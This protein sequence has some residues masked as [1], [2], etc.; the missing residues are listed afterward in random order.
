MRCD[1]NAMKMTPNPSRLIGI[2][3]GEQR[4]GCET[5]RKRIQD[6][7]NFTSPSGAWGS[8]IDT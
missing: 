5:M 4:L 8:L 1:G 2:N 3:G 7:S 6:E